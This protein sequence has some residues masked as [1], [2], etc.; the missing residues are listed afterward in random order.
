[1]RKATAAV[2]I[3]GA[4]GMVPLGGC[5]ATAAAGAGAVTYAYVEGDTDGYVPNPEQEVIEASKKVLRNTDIIVLEAKKND[6]G[7]TRIKG[8]TPNGTSVE[9][10]VRPREEA[11][12]VA[13]RVGLI[14]DDEAGAALFGKI[15]QELGLSVR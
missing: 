5:I 4:V 11:T 1:M 3:L 6:E 9:V 14:G 10:T 13:V 12:F 15:R 8:E 7:R 2:L